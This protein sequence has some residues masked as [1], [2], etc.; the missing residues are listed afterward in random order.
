MRIEQEKVFAA[1]V[2]SFNSAQW[3]VSQSRRRNLR[4]AHENH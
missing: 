2:R 4:L 1:K 3:V